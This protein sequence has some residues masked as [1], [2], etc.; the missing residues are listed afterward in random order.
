M[1]LLLFSLHHHLQ[2]G[3]EEAKEEG[4]EGAPAEVAEGGV[5]HVV[6]SNQASTSA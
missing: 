5:K 3:P 6:A 4:V 2:H 1:H